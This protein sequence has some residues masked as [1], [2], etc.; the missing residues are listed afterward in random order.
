LCG[1]AAEL[2]GFDVDALVPLANKVG[3]T[4]ADVQ[5]PLSA[6]DEAK[7]PRRI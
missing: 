6:E 3:P 5:A 2:Y 7:I 1:N 4:V